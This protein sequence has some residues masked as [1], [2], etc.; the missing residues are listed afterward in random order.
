[1]NKQEEPTIEVPESSKQKFTSPSRKRKNVS[2]IYKGTLEEIEDIDACLLEGFLVASEKAKIEL[3]VGVVII[4]S[5][6]SLHL[7]FTPKRS[8]FM[9]LHGELTYEQLRMGYETYYTGKIFQ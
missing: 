9:Y 6:R 1:M 5:D 4:S 8:F 2:V 3:N 7:Y